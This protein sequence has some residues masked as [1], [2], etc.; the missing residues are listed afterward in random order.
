MLLTDGIPS[1]S[2]NE[3]ANIW[4]CRLP[5][6]PQNKPHSLPRSAVSNFDARAEFEQTTRVV[7]DGGRQRH[8]STSTSAINIR[9]YPSNYQD[10]YTTPKSH[11]RRPCPPD[12]APS[13]TEKRA[14]SLALGSIIRGGIRLGK[15]RAS[16]RREEAG[17]GNGAKR[18]RTST[19]EESWRKVSER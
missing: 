9:S 15:K 7:C 2:T 13:A 10:C 1:A 17:K 19:A 14:S 3:E 12:Q 11:E 8:E 16:G 4:P 5:T 18:R 6:P